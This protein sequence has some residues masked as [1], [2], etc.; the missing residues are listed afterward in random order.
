MKTALARLE[1]RTPDWRVLSGVAV[2]IAFL[3]QSFVTQTHIHFPGTTD[4]FDGINIALGKQ[5]AAKAA[6]L[7]ASAHKP[8]QNK[9]S[10]ADDT[11]NCPLCQASALSGAFVTP[12][13][14][15][16]VL[17]SL[18][19]SIAPAIISLAAADAFVSHSWQG[20]APP[21]N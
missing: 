6:P 12:A 2:L 20:R 10:P 3:F 16:F 15:V 9:K 8:A 14:I 19:L 18:P 5:D 11:S 13:A 4:R 7:K 1:H 17:P 21:R